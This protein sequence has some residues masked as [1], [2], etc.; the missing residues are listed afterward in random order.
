MTS[1]PWPKIP[2]RFV[3]RMLSGHTALGLALSALLYIVCL[4]G[5]LVVFHNEFSRWEQPF[6]AETEEIAPEAFETM[7]AGVL[8]RSETLPEQVVLLLPTE[9]VPRAMAGAGEDYWFADSEGNLGEPVQHAFSEFLVMLHMYLHLPG[10]LGLTVVG[11]LGVMMLGLV[12]SG[13]FAHPR[14]FRDAFHFRRTRSARLAETDLHNRLSV[15]GAPFH[16]VIALSGAIIGLASI[17]AWALALAFHE[18]DTTAVFPAIFGE[19]AETGPAPEG[20]ADLETAY[21]TLL[22]ERPD[23]QPWLIYANGPGTDAQSIEI[24]T[25]APGQLAY[26]DQVQFDAAG[27]MLGSTGMSDGETGQKMAAALYSLHFGW[28]GGLTVKFAYLALGLALTAVCASGFTLWLIKRR[29]KG[30]PAPRLER[31]WTAT[32]W[33]TPAALAAT[34]AGSLSGLLP[35]AALTPAFWALLA[36]IHILATAFGTKTAWSR[37]LRLTAGALTLAGLAA[38]HVGYLGDFRGEASWGV[39]AGLAIAALALLASAALPVLLPFRSPPRRRE[40]MP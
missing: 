15:W 38:H 26:Y 28:F 12:L 5:T 20:L 32:V 19:E 7:V 40:A 17:A 18:G 36:L 4:S 6:V 23:L 2:A 31:A 10:V 14:I 16:I 27:R 3:A 34:L 39:S 9:D 24:L 13:F 35:E 30:K 33:G 11:L 22:A 8:E 25:K 1:L 21:R 37:G 29:E